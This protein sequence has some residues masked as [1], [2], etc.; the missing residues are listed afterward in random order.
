MRSSA[1]Q[2]GGQH[3]HKNGAFKTKRTLGSRSHGPNIQ[4]HRTQ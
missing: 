3:H 2:R 1:V 4:I